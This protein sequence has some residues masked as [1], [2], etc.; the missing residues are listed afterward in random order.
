MDPTA[1][2]PT[3]KQARSLGEWSPCARGLERIGGT[4]SVRAPNTGTLVGVTSPC[5][6]APDRR[7]RDAREVARLTAAPASRALR[8][9]AL[10]RSSS[11]TVPVRHQP[12]QQINHDCVG[13]CGIRCARRNPCHGCAGTQASAAIANRI[14]NFRKCLVTRHILSHLILVKFD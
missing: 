14:G 2:G 1:L 12:L 6:R 9:D 11:V 8:W 5:G 4:A 10:M 3:P 13:L 7:W